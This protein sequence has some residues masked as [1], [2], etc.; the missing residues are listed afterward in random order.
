MARLFSVRTL[1]PIVAVVLALLFPPWAQDDPAAPMRDYAGTKTSNGHSFILRPP[2]AAVAFDSRVYAPSANIPVQVD[3]SQ[4]L[5]EIL[6]VAVVTIFLIRIG[7]RS[8]LNPD[9]T[10]RPPFG[11]STL[12]MA[13]LVGLILPLP[14]VGVVSFQPVWLLVSSNHGLA[15]WAMMLIFWLPCVLGAYLILGVGGIVVRHSQR[16]DDRA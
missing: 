2:V 4:W 8:A 6:T 13:G 9:D 3:R 14:L 5:R 11:R 10:A 16:P 1:L 15:G 12:A 7:R